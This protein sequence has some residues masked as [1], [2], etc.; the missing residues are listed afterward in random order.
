MNTPIANNFSIERMI[1]MTNVAN[2]NV[3]VEAENTGADFDFLKALIQAPI[4]AAL[5]AIMSLAFHFSK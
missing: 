4:L 5:P 3:A 1:K 2:V